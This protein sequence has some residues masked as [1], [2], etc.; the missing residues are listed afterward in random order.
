[1]TVILCLPFLKV[2]ELHFQILGQFLSACIGWVH[3]DK[4]SKLWI[5]FHNLTIRESEPL[6][7]LLFASQ[8]DSTLLGTY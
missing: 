7:L 4:D 1:M 3:S 2:P 8:Y 5:H 6:F